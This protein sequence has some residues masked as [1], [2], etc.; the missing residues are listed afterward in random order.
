MQKLP[1]PITA[2]DDEM[3]VKRLGKQSAWKAHEAD[4]LN[5][6]KRYQAKGGNPFDVTPA[7][8][9]AEIGKRQYELY[10]SRRNGGPLKRIREQ[11]GLKSCPVCGSPVTGD[12]DH[13]LPRKIYPEF[14]IMRA[15]LVPACTH[16]NSGS[17][18]TMVSGTAPERFIHPYFDGWA[19][20]DLWF[21][22]IAPPFEAATFKPK[23]LNVLSKARRLI[24]GFH[25]DNV[26]GKQ[27][28]RSMETI[29]SNLPGQLKMRNP[30]LG[31]SGLI[32]ELQLEL[33]V[34]AMSSG[35]N[36]W[37]A[38]LLRGI[39]QNEAALDYLAEQIALADLP[40][41][42]AGPT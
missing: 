40:P 34:A 37:P 32:D 11:S 9:A 18:G 17:K 21:V 28:A 36:S 26:L 31:E 14:S 35:N 4:W 2:A 38:A 25:L 13:Y 33:R 12:L 3:V 23:P 7:G 41:E 29:W 1:L 15:N 22:A 27:F 42:T 16:C 6:Y 5:A 8:F 19:S 10:D 39:L 24:V 30:S 20:G